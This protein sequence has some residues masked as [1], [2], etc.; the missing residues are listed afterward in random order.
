MKKSRGRKLERF[1]NEDEMAGSATDFEGGLITLRDSKIG[2]KAVF[3]NT[4][5][6]AALTGLTRAEGNPY[7]IVGSKDGKP[8]T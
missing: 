2:G 5:A 6:A 8:F 3:L 1:L 4:P 7:V